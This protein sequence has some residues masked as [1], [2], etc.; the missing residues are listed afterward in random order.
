MADGDPPMGAGEL[1]QQLFK[2]SEVGFQSLNNMAQI[3]VD[4]VNSAADTPITLHQALTLLPSPFGTDYSDTIE[5]NGLDVP[6][7][8]LIRCTIASEAAF[9]PVLAMSNELQQL[10]AIDEYQHFAS[11]AA[12]TIFQRMADIGANKSGCIFDIIKKFNMFRY[13]QC[14]SYS[15]L[16]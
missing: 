1:L 7:V 2:I 15:E 6:T 10:D 13:A 9:N 8:M 5:F 16:V 11:E 3:A 14:T 12:L 4:M